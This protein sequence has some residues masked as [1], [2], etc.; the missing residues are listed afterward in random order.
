[1]KAVILAGGRG[2]RLEEESI[3]RPK[4]LVEIG[5][6]PILWHILNIYAAH[7]IKDFII[8]AGY[9]GFL[10]K[11]YFSRLILYH[12]DITVR[13]GENNITYHNARPLDWTVTVVDTGL[14]S[15]TGG[16]VK[17][18][19]RYLNPDE[20]F[21]LTYG[22]GLADIDIRALLAAHARLGGKVTMTTVVPPARFGAVQVEGD[23]VT[24]FA[25]KPMVKDSRINGGFFVVDPG[26]LDLIRDDAT[27]WESEILDQLAR[28]G[29]LRAY[30]HDGFW[31]PMDTVREKMALEALWAAGKAPWKTWD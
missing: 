26:V 13:V 31:Q 18:I 25:E 2:S 11:E 15:A 20:P 4:P 22:D 23:T 28:S 30:R 12:N 1:M 5:E 9:K 21:C 27:V 14:N 16:R 10:I 7:G 19:G 3:T 29:D 8:C 17:R 6:H 24:A